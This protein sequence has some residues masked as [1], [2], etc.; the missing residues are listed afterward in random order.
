VARFESQG[1][2]ATLH[3]L[4]QSSPQGGRALLWNISSITLPLIATLVCFANAIGN[5]FTNWDDPLYVVENDLITSLSPAHIQ[6]MFST[7]LV[8]N[9]HPLTVLSLALDYWLYGLNPSGFHAM[10][11]AIHLGNVA[12]VFLV[13]QMI[14][15]NRAV[16]MVTALLFGIH[17]RIFCISFLPHA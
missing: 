2:A 14:V 9:Y 5:G 1:N 10:N 6:A 16:S 13:T 4:D 12:L 17:P 8:G 7:F 15:G 3:E 11:V